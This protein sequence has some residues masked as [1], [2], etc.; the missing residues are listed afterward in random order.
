MEAFAS[1]KDRYLQKGSF[2]VNVATLTMGTVIAQTITIAMSPILTRLYLPADFGNFALYISIVST[3][4]V[5]AT[6][7][8]ELAIV[9]PEKD[10]DAFCL[11]VLSAIFSLLSSIIILFIVWVFYE[12]IA[13]MFDNNAISKWLYFIPLT[14][15]F[16]GIYSTTNYWL[17]RKRQYK[18]L[19]VNR[20]YQSGAIAATQISMGLGEAGA[21]GLVGGWIVGQG[22]SA[23]TL[24]WQV[25]KVAGG[26]K[27]SIRKSR[28]I[29]IATR[30]SSFPK[31]LI[32]GHFMNT[33]SSQLPVILLNAL[34]D[35]S[36]AGCYSLT[37]RVIS[38]PMS[39]IG[40]SIGDV[41]RQK[42]ADNFVKKG[43]C[44]QIY[45]KTLSVLSIIATP[46]FIVVL[47]FSPKLFDF[48]FGKEWHIAGEY[49]QIMG[50]M[51]FLQFITTPLS[52]MFIIAE[53][54]QLDLVWQSFRLFF[55]IVPFIVAY[56]Y[57][58][59][60]K[61]AIV[62]Y[63]LSYFLLY[64]VNGIMAYKFSKGRKSTI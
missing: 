50:V 45:K 48:I 24:G 8:Y 41:F 10:E 31:Y 22:V 56:Y 49:A 5:I 18:S 37:Y 20:L 13:R 19:A 63:A 43:E 6:G 21:T 25:W 11:V 14:V 57:C 46:P 36:F 54:Q 7:R 2:A 34:F 15:L 52:N 42:A 33:L 44:I 27:D 59:T 40:I 4:S 17:N 51:F 35:P 39:I 26:K 12:P 47:L 53:K 23:G 30:F 1:L 60:P 16:M 38:L 32:V 55:S 28:I 58:R 64:L 3:L 62:L 29:N 9:L 61:F